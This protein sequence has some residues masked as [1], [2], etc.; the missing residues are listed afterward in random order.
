MPQHRLAARTRR[1]FRTSRALQIG[2]VAAFW[3]AGKTVVD[4]TGLPV[5]GGVVGMALALLML[6]LGRIRLDSVKRGADW[7]LGEMLLF[8]VPVV[9]AVLNHHEFLGLLGVKLVAIIALST[10]AVMAVTA[11]TV[12]LCFRWRETHGRPAPVD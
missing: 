7:F 9:L 5:P 6:S 8:F 12:D 4:V 2:V 11:I 10:V 1:L 3:L